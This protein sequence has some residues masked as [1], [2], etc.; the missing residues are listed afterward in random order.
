MDGELFFEVLQGVE[1]MARI[2]TLL[3]LAV[4]ALD[5]TIV[6][7][8]VGTDQLMPN[9]QFFGSLLK[10]GREV[11]LTVGKAVGKLKAVVSLNTF[12]FNPLAGIPLGQPFQEVCGGVS[13]LLRIGSQETKSGKLVNGGVLE[14]TQLWVGNTAT[15]Y[16]FYVHLDSL[17]G[18]GHLLIRFGFV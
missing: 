5:L 7:G 15:R 9:F 6:S 2:E 16:D 13:R 4:A 17:A 1:R 3:V 14:Q 11:P 12:H 8:S 10:K 18:I